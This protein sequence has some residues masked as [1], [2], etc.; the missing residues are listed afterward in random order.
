MFE[1]FHQLPHYFLVLAD[2]ILL[3]KFLFEIQ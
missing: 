1:R 2:Q 3:G